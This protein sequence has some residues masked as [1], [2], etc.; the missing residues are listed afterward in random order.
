MAILLVMGLLQIFYIMID[1]DNDDNY[2][3]N[4]SLIFRYNWNSKIKI[5]E[6]WCI[7]FR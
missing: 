7:Q 5:C 4:G 3:D 1:N 6:Y 2:N